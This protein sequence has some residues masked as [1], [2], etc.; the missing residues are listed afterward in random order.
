MLQE[1][2]AA[3]EMTCGEPHARF[4]LSQATVAHH[5]TAQPTTGVSIASSGS[6]SASKAGS[7]PHGR[8][9][10][11]WPPSGGCMDLNPDFSDLLS[12]FSDAEARF[13]VVGAYATILYT[14]PR[15][16]KDLDIWID[17]TPEHAERVYRA[18]QKF[19]APLADLKIEDLSAPGTL[20]QIG[21]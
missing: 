12:A 21:V 15:F 11:K 6:G 7:R 10:K 13:L 5:N 17:A 3:G 2:R 19:G 18:L 4:P 1:I 20:F 14:T 9:S 8:W 16:T